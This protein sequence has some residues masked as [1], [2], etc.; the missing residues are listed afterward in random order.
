MIIVDSIIGIL[1]SLLGLRSASLFT[2]EKSILKIV[3][4][5]SLVEIKL[6]RRNLGDGYELSLGSFG[7]TIQ[8]VMVVTIDNKRYEL[9]LGE[10]T[11]GFNSE[12]TTATVDKQ[13]QNKAKA[14]CAQLKELGVEHII[15]NNHKL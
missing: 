1:R 6:E 7:D 11:N 5:S 9:L 15:V 2:D 12:G 10:T 13:Y 3:N 4:R 14:F 8:Y